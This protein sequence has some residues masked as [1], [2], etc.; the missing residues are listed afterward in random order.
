MGLSYYRFS[1]SWPRILPNGRP[2]SASADGLRYYNALINELLDNGI[3]P[4]VTLYHWDLPQALEDEGGFLSDDFPEW[5]NDYANYCF[6]Q[7]GD[8]VKF[9]ITFNEPL[10]HCCA[11]VR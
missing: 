10:E 4:Q 8:R 5:F 9:W 3:N 7:F 6:E 2:D 11:R 1:L